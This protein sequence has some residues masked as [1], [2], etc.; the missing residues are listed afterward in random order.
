VLGN[1]AASA[2][3][4]YRGAGRGSTTNPPQARLPRNA[5]VDA[6]ARDGRGRAIEVLDAEWCKVAELARNA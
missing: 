5:A 6:S 2:A 3:Q 1:G 4:R